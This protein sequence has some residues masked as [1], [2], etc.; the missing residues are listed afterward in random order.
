MKKPV[1]SV[2][3]A[4]FV[5]ALAVASALSFVAVGEDDYQTEFPLYLSGL[6]YNEKSMGVTAVVSLIGDESN[7]I[8]CP[9]ATKINSE[10]KGF[11][12]STNKNVYFISSKLLAESVD[13]M[14]PDEVF[15]NNGKIYDRAKLNF[16]F[17]YSTKYKSITGGSTQTLQNIYVHTFL[18]DKNLDVTQ[19]ELSNKYPVSA[20]WYSVLIGTGII[21]AMFAVGITCYVKRTK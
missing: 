9:S 8:N 17:R 2:L 1:I 10:D 14:L 6:I 20:N 18:L 11:W 4:L 12:F 21:I 16:E 15:V 13:N 5:V 3:I 19:I 7:R